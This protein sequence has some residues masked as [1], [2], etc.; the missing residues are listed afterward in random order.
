[1]Y[2]LGVVQVE[3]R[4]R[5]VLARHDKTVV[6][7]RMEEG[8]SIPDEILSIKN[9]KI[10]TGLEG[11]SV[12]RRDLKLPLKTARTVL[13]ALPF[14]LEP[15]FPFSLDQS[16]V[17][18]QMHPAEKET[19]VVAWGVALEAVGAHL[20][21]WKSLGIEPDLVSSETLALARWARHYYPDEAELVVV[22]GRVGI[23]IDQDKVVCAMQ[24]P[25]PARLKLFL[26]QKY[27]LFTWIE[28]GAES[29]EFAPAIGLALEPFQKQP[30]QFIPKGCVST[31][32]KKRGRFILKT[33]A[34]AGAGLTV[35]LLLFSE[36]IFLFQEKKL[37]NQIALFYTAPI[38][39][40]K[41]SVDRLRE[42]IIR[43]T[44][45]IPPVV[46]VPTV[47]DVL[48]WLSTFSAPV[49][50]HHLEYELVDHL[51]SYRAQVSLEFQAEAPENA[52]QFVK[53][54]Q[55]SPTF[56][57]STHELKWTTHPQGYKLS[58]IV[59]KSS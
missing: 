22:H 26:K 44:K 52:D 11:A 15:L 41:E 4:L 24:S 17:Y 49:E 29:W 33:A 12:L 55:Q 1:M 53:Q 16:I 19:V 54:L 58:F 23:A 36:A 51:K 8:L 21:Q 31:R 38:T 57:E 18:P 28:S 37:K 27:P 14:Q 2:S 47:Q 43:E 13:Q 40:V 48:A 5:W 42:S 9:L 25:D 56:V 7:E 46:N 3:E 45:T 59:R 39:S 6:I 50:I 30:C 10:V 35:A 34:L 32:Q 20:Q